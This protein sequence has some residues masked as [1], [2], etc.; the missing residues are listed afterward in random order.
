MAL[1]ARFGIDDRH[2][3]MRFFNFGVW[4]IFFL[5][6]IYSGR[7]TGLTT[8]EFSITQ[9][10][11]TSFSGTEA[12]LM[13]Y[14]EL[15][16]IILNSLYNFGYF[17]LN[18]CGSYCGIS[19]DYSRSDWPLGK[20]AGQNIVTEADRE[21]C[22]EKEVN[23]LFKNIFPCM[24]SFRAIRIHIDTTC[25]SV[26]RT[27]LVWGNMQISSANI[28]YNNF[29]SHKKEGYNTNGFCNLRW[30]LLFFYLIFFFFFWVKEKFTFDMWHCSL[31]W[32]NRN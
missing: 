32:D 26:L 24:F 25:M 10:L 5:Y 9:E 6:Y 27:V 22:R 8:I 7:S 23:C 19:K 2:K 3:C 11:L 18:Y 21:R 1:V 4:A 17:E 14:L 16:L 30:F 15:L 31:R 13:D 29:N 28:S 12:I 20:I